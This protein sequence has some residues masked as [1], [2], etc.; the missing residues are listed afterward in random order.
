MHI[1]IITST[2]LSEFSGGMERVCCQLRRALLAKGERVSAFAIGCEAA[3]DVYSFPDSDNLSSAENIKFLHNFI[4]DEKVDILWLN[5][6]LFAQFLCA[7]RACRGTL[8]KIV[9]TMHTDPLAAVK[10]LY[11]FRDLRF[12]QWKLSKSLSSLL[13]Y[14][15]AWAKQPLGL[16]LRKKYLKSCYR[17][18]FEGCD[19]LTFLT[20][21]HAEKFRQIIG[22]EGEGKLYALPNPVE[23]SK[24][25]KVKKKKQVL[26]VGRLLW[27]KRV[28]RIL[29]AWKVIESRYPDWSLVVVGDG[30]EK[31][32]Y[33]C[34]AKELKLKNV[35]FV[36][37]Q[38]A[39][40]YFA[41][42]A[43]LVFSS[44]HEG[45]G[46]VLIEAMQQG[47][48]PI[49]FD[50]PSTR[51]IIDDGKNGVLVKPFDKKL[52]ANKLSML[53]SKDDKREEMS[54][55]ARRKALQYDINSISQ[56]WMKLF[57]DVLSER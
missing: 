56:K 35:N 55:A 15:H 49:A 57:A 30:T 31:M 26:F 4:L 14:I 17:M 20:S 52:F 3:D 51:E 44:T 12:H 36:G 27:Q 43:M 9:Y 11:D 37:S 42:S 24:I 48:V 19:A 46:M 7:S 8:A 32:G 39:T 18:L 25:D 34:Y 16:Y 21:A 1:C 6:C 40:N 5:T 54:I 50:I 47:C 13:S 41:E 29:D 22:Y 23:K 33:E 38:P 45:F 28:D 53:M 10:D 2:T